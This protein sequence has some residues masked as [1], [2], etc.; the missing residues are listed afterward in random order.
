M[1]QTRLSYNYLEITSIA[2]TSK[3]YKSNLGLQ[4]EINEND[5]IYILL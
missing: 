2:F 4:N 5:F 3:A 1:S